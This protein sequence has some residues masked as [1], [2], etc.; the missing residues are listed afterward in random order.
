MPRRQL[1]LKQ[2]KKI[3]N[4]KLKNIAIPIY[5]INLDE[6]TDRDTNMISQLQ[7][8]NYT[9]FSAIGH[10][11]NILDKYKN[12][13]ESRYLNDIKKLCCCLSHLY[14]IK[15]AYDNNL[16]NVII[17]EDDIDLSI[18]NHTYKK[19][20]DFWHN[21]LKNTDI[22]QLFTSKGD[23]YN[24][25]EHKLKM[26]ERENN[27]WGTCG[28]MINYNGMKKIMKLYDFV[29]NKFDLEK[30]N[31]LL[32]ADVF[33]YNICKSHILNLPAINIIPPSIFPSQL[34]N[35]SNPVGLILNS[36]SEYISKNTNKIIDSIER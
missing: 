23:F 7:N 12:I 32:L 9:R 15:L 36:T 35:D 26:T 27:C 34:N 4:R 21:N 6:C 11:N 5:Y 33:I 2:L 8:H 25:I 31:E 22:L 14:A 3:H 28:Y 10:K 13:P 20:N 30:N 17:F 16:D 1:L 24:I 18:F 29:N 19:I